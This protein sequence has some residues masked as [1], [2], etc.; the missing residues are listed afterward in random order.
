MVG[1]FSVF[2]VELLA[3][4][5]SIKICNMQFSI[6]QAP[7]VLILFLSISNFFKFQIVLSS[8]VYL[9]KT[10]IDTKIDAKENKSI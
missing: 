6:R 3:L 1:H 8:E 7:D 2:C 5:L 9:C 4:L 10:K